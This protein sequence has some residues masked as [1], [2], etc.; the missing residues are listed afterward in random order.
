MGFF[1]SFLKKAVP[2]AIRDLDYRVST[3]DRS[4]FTESDFERKL[5]QIHKSAVQLD[6]YDKSEAI[7]ALHVLESNS[8]LY[9]EERR[10][11]G[12]VLNDLHRY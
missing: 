8:R 10:L 1:D 4:G 3:R 9:P 5:D 12:K 2:H 7:H 6:G 11:L